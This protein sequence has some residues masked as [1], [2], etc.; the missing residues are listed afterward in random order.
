MLA[1]VLGSE[2]IKMY[3]NQLN[4]SFEFLNQAFKDN[5]LDLNK[6]EYLNLLLVYKLANKKDITLSFY[7]ES[8]DKKIQEIEGKFELQDNDI[9]EIQKAFIQGL[10]EDSSK[11]KDTFNFIID[12]AILKTV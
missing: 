9:I 12:T 3:T 10:K 7:K 2:D 6:G 4:K 11:S 8:I 5:D 1:F